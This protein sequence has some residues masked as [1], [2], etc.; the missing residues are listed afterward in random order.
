MST[1]DER[2]REWATPRQREFID[3][4]DLHGSC[5]AAERA[6]NVSYGLIARSMRGL[7]KLAAAKGYSPEHALTHVI[8]D[9]YVAKGH[10]TYYDREGKPTQ[11]W[12]KTK[13]DDAAYQAML[14][15]AVDAYISETVQPIYP[16]PPMP[17]RGTD[18]IPWINIGDGHLGMLAHEAETGAN[19]DLKIAEREL[20]AAISIA[21]DDMGEHDRIVIQDMGDMTHYENFSA[22]TEHSG[23]ALDYDTRFPKMIR[24]YSRVMRFIVE[25]VLEKANT[26]D[27]I[28]NQGNHSRTN[29]IWMAEILRVAY[30]HTGRVN[31]LDNDS[32]FIGYRMGNTFVMCHH[33][34]K[35]RPAKLAHVMATDFAVD[36]GEAR[37]RYIDIGHI[38]H[39]M[40]L[41][42]HPGVVVESFNQ[43]AEKDK[44][45]AEG[46][47][48]SRQCLTI[49]HRSRTYGEVGRQIL[50]IERV[51]DV[52]VA[53][54][55]LEGRTIEL[56][57]PRRAYAV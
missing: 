8:P 23:H 30:G 10:S 12:V 21:V 40:V 38:H 17:G 25:K 11:Q 43:L 4:I 47:W 37:H 49:I 50:P 32:V 48:R 19:F 9:P 52:I 22:T 2:L 13:L 53:A 15:E 34:D 56:A 1:I 24:V 16:A 44:Y 57:R 31:V 39:N 55:A 35:C 7:K 26:V 46:G 51:R 6:L 20:C 45:A 36:W 29:D 41:K 18:I 14:R 27:V 3:A 33:S 5:R 28:V 42:E 54:A